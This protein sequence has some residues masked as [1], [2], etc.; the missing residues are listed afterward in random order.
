MFKRLFR[1]CFPKNESINSSVNSTGNSSVN[2]HEKDDRISPIQNGKDEIPLTTSVTQPISA[3]QQTSVGEQKKRKIIII[4]KKQEPKRK[5]DV[6]PKKVRNAVWIKYHGESLTGI[7]YCCGKE[8]TRYN[9]GWHCSH[10]L[11]D[12]KGGEEIVENLTTCCPH[13]NLSM[14]SQNLYVYM[15]EN[16]MQGPGKEHIEKYLK[17]HP[18]QINDKRESPQQKE[19][20]KAKMVT[21]MMPMKSRKK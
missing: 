3:S 11:S 4:R 18:D 13:C 16:N 9:G 19:K 6:I 21:K 12:V 15:K 10:I 5:K 14:G 20:K 1:C 17:E 7:C 2:Q 8:I